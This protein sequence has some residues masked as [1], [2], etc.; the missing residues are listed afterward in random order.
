MER[1]ADANGPVKTLQ[2][3][4]RFTRDSVV[5]FLMN[6][7]T[8]AESVA[9]EMSSLSID[10][11]AQSE[12]SERYKDVSKS[13]AEDFASDTAWTPSEDSDSDSDEDAFE[14]EPPMRQSARK[15]RNSAVS[16]PRLHVAAVPDTLPCREQEFEDIFR[17]V[18]SKLLDG[19]GG[20]MYISGVPGTGKTA[21]VK[22]VVRTLNQAYDSGDLPKFNFIEVNGMRLTEPRQAYVQILKLDLLWTRKQD[23]MYNI[24]DWPTKPRARLIVLAVANTMDLP[25]RIMIKRVSSRLQ[26]ASDLNLATQEQLFLKAIVAEFKHSGIEEAEFGKLYTHHLALCRFESRFF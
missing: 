21:T 15:G 3:V 10:S 20:C 4:G 13:D 6:D 2:N 19:T 5:D 14:E 24:F 1:N 16:T 9:S 8:D 26:F 12:D 25:E 18:E 11:K 22:E 23:V 7:N 17:F